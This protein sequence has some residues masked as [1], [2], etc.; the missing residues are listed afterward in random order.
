MNRNF[1]KEAIQMVNNQTKKGSTWFVIRKCKLKPHKKYTSG[2][3]SLRREES[4]QPGPGEL[5][6]VTKCS[7]TG[8]WQWLHNCINLLRIIWLNAYNGWFLPYVSY[9]SVKLFRKT[10]LKSPLR[11]HYAPTRMA[12]MEKTGSTKCWWSRGTT[13]LSRTADRGVN[14]YNNFGKLFNSSLPQLNQ[15]LPDNAAI[16]PLGACPTGCTYVQ[17]KKYTGVFIAS[18]FIVAPIWK[19]HSP[20]Q[21][22]NGRLINCGIL[23]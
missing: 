7:K 19:Q 13:K 5:S 2:C 14:R 12:T 8:L 18:P 6:G 16:P 4:L 10:N 22:Q 3:L 23:T 1:T 11:Y 20:H 17:Q 15:R 9:I 21:Q